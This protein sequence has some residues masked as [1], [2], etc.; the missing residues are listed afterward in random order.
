MMTEWASA[1]PN[2][3]GRAQERRHQSAKGK[4]GRAGWAGTCRKLSVFPFQ[5]GRSLWRRGRPRASLLPYLLLSGGY[6]ALLVGLRKRLGGLQ[7][8]EQRLRHDADAAWETQLATLTPPPPHAWFE[9]AV[10]YLPAQA[11]GGDFYA[12]FPGGPR[13]GVI[14]GDV[15]GKG[16]P[17]AL[18]STSISQLA[19]WLRPMEDPDGFLANMNRELLEHLRPETFASMVLA[20]LDSATKRL[21]IYNA[22]H[23]P[24]LIVSGGTVQ[25]L[26]QAN[27]PLG[28]FPGVTF[29]PES[30]PLRRGD[31]LVLYSDGFIEARNAAG[32]E[33]TLEG[34][35]AMVRRHATL[36]PEELAS[37]LIDETRAFGE[38]ID[39][40]TL[41]VV[42]YRSHRLKRNRLA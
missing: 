21:V 5:W 20:F 36:P 4:Q 31:T 24:G 11:V 16:I 32:E 3:G 38:V 1:G 2:R 7:R 27:L 33:L 14:L 42:R 22:G 29:V 8:E 41:V 10:R 37:R 17:A 39:D 23:P 35:E 12:F 19:R 13:L 40:L 34:L 15:S 6:A 26:R 28:M 25:H 30:W 9:V 18:A